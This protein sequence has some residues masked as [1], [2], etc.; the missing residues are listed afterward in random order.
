MSLKK[1]IF[2]VEARKVFPG[3]YRWGLK[4]VSIRWSFLLLDPLIQ[5][6][7]CAGSAAIQI[8][9]RELAS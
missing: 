1:T 9:A 3:G 6:Y 8:E 5:S 7:P 4:V 2:F